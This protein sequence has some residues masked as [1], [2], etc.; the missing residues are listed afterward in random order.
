MVEKHG[1]KSF[2]DFPVWKKAMDVS[3]KAFE[4]T[5]GLPY[6]EEKG[7]VS[8]IRRA[9]NSISANIAEAY[10]RNGI[11]DK[12]HFYFISRGSSFELQSHLIYGK[13][14]K[15]FAVDE[16]EKL[17]EEVDDI[18]FSLNKIISKLE[19]MKKKK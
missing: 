2:R 3:V 12:Q 14:V 4:L 19:T 1:Y 9:S 7:L 16:A 18:I 6:F 8:Q 15:Y 17:L 13:R 11:K 10:G 5:K